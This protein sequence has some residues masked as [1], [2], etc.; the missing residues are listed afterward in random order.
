MEFAK[1]TQ[2]TF[3]GTGSIQDKFFVE[4]ISSLNWALN[5]S[6]PALSE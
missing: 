2:T 4:T 5:V 6:K 3:S 1:P